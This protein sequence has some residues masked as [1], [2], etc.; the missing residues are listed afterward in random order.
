M[1]VHFARSLRSLAG[2]GSAPDPPRHRAKK[3]AV[4][5]HPGVYAPCTVPQ[6]RNTHVAAWHIT[7]DHL[8]YGLGPMQA[9]TRPGHAWHDAALMHGRCRGGTFACS[10]HGVAQR[11]W[12]FREGCTLK[13]GA[14]IREVEV[15][16]PPASL[17]AQRT[18]L[19]ARPIRTVDNIS[20][21]MLKDAVALTRREQGVRWGEAQ[22]CEAERGPPDRSFPESCALTCIAIQIHSRLDSTSVLA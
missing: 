16:C 6:R 9:L 4:H 1:H 2:G 15:H 5:Q 7:C 8:G 10:A 22:P 17:S 13:H 11:K 19:R 14:S 12:N 18:R 20:Y 21:S 3:I